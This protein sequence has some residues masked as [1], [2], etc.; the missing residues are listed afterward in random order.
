MSSGPLTKVKSIEE[1]PLDKIVLG[2]AQVR[3]RNVA[4]DLD[5]LAE[6]IKKVGLLHPIIVHEL[7]DGN[8][9]L[10]SGQRRFLAHQ[11]IGAKTIKALILGRKMS[12]TEAK[13]ISLTEN[14]VRLDASR[15]DYI[16]ACTFLFKQYGSV[17]AVAN[18]LGLSYAKVS[19]Y[20][21]YDQLVPPLREMVDKNVIK[22]KTALRAQQAAIKEDATIDE[23]AAIALAKEMRTMSSDR[24]KRM[25]SV[26]TENPEASLT[27]KIELGKKQAS[28]IKLNVALDENL[29]T[30]LKRYSDDEGTTEDDAAATLIEE[31]LE[32]KGYIK[33]E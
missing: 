16:D 24:Q 18:E 7:E 27:E 5:E 9:E 33:K 20:I 8:Y 4:K 6:S 32:T 3:T 25:I 26:V 23:D 22:L 13:K 2:T 12:E 15:L 29:H 17:P 10:I 11:R 30:S 28:V 31:G 19:E 21:K 1:I 14:F